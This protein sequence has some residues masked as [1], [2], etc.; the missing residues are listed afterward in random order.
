MTLVLLFLSWYLFYLFSVSFIFV[1][2]FIAKKFCYLFIGKMRTKQRKIKMWVDTEL[3]KLR[4]SDIT[5]F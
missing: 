1:L 4:N 5:S 2:V 3:Y